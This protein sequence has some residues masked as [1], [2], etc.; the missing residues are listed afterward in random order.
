MDVYRAIILLLFDLGQ[1]G[2]WSLT[3]REE[4]RVNVFNNRELEKMFGPNRVEVPGG[5]RKLHNEEHYDF[6]CSPDFIGMTIKKKNG[7]GGAWGTRE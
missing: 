1:S 5:W 2:T 4:Q 6:L 3:L 7:S